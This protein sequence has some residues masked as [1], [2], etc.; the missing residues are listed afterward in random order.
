MPG[1]LFIQDEDNAGSFTGKVLMSMGTTP[2]YHCLSNPFP[3]SVLSHG[4]DLILLELYREID[5]SIELLKRMEKHCYTSGMNFPSVIVVSQLCSDSIETVFRVA[6][7]G[8]FFFEPLQ[9][10]ELRSAIIQTFKHDT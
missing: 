7:G 4:F 2:E 8:F 6:R 10:D 3:G 9:E 1:I 5:S